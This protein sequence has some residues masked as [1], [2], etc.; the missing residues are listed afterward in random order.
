MKQTEIIVVG[1]GP[2]GLY[3]AGMLT[4]EKK[5]Y[6]L[7]EAEEVLGGQ[8]ASLY[9]AKMVEDVPAYTPRPAIEIVNALVAGVPKDNI[10]MNCEVVEIKEDKDGVTVK[11]KAGDYRSNFV[12]IATGLGFHKP[13]P[14]GIENEEKCSN[15]LYS[16]KDPEILK[17]KRI[18]IFG[19]GDSA[20]DWAKQLSENSSCVSLIHRRT[21][22]RGNP[23]T[24]KGCCLKLYL[25]YVPEKL[26]EIDGICRDIT[27]KNVTDSTLVTLPVDYVM[28]NY[29]QIP[30]TTTFG[31]QQT[32]TGFGF[33]A[34]D[35]MSA[36]KRIYVVGDCLY[37][38]N[39]KKR[40]EPGM[41]EV[42]LALQS[43][44][45]FGRD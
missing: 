7:L 2:I 14:L 4:K 1:G 44:K 35:D 25:P 41:E 30:S 13:R 26:T 19:G 43:I 36:T 20:L 32:T 3:A 15:I 10:V 24:I 23:D 45:N 34:K 18:A 8:P 21:E 6:L 42:K 17:N 39:Y 37:N 33:L 12:I 5:D 40:I 27:I 31:L 29:G 38:P 11:T 9:P 28:V 22:F 16:L